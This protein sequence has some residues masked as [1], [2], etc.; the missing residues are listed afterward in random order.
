MKII[1]DKLPLFENPISLIISS[2]QDF[3]KFIFRVCKDK[4]KLSGLDVGYFYID[5]G[6]NVYVWL[7]PQKKEE[8]L[9]CLIHESI[10]VLF[11]AAKC[12][13]IKHCK[14]SEEFFAYFVEKLVEK[15]I[16]RM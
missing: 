8:M 13:D 7:L 4:I 5:N 6:I 1:R 11:D 9:L 12:R 15:F 2:R 3:I 16:K 10:H 14:K